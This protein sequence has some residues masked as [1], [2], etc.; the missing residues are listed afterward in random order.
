MRRVEGEPEVGELFDNV[1]DLELVL[2]VHGEVD[3]RGVGLRGV[4]HV[5][6]GGNQ[7]L[8]E[9]FLYGLAD[10]ENFARGLHLGAELR[11]D[12]VE[13]LE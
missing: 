3:A 1:Y 2:V 12:V 9:G 7:A 5:E 6:A 10:A 11:V 13:L 4:L 8:V